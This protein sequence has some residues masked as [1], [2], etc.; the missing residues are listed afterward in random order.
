MNSSD[1]ILDTY[2]FGGCNSS[3]EAFSLGK[4]VITLPSKYLPE[5]LLM[6]FIKK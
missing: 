6:D 2:P 5:D 1:I 4:I 3:L